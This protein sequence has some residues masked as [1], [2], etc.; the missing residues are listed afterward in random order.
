M[1]LAL[2]LN[3]AGALRHYNTAPTFEFEM[4]RRVTNLMWTMVPIREIHEVSYDYHCPCY[5]DYSTYM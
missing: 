4:M 2:T 5:T 1:L 3:D